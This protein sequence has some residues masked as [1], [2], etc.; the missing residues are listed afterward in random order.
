[1][2]PQTPFHESLG[3]QKTDEIFNKDDTLSIKSRV[4]VLSLSPEPPQ[5]II[6][7]GLATPSIYLPNLQTNTDL[8]VSIE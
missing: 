1:M 4:R 5:V 7:E 8:E 2:T 3:L 6:V